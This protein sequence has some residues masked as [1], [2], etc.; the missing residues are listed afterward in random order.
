M[1]PTSV[2]KP[3]ANILDVKKKIST[4][5]VRAAKSKRKSIKAGTTPW[6][7]KPNRKVNLEK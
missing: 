5:Q 6:A 1:T 2:K 4:H 7:L 3:S